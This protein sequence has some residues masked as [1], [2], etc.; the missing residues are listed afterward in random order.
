MAVAK[1]GRGT[2]FDELHNR[3]GAKMFRV[4]HRITRNRQDAE[5]AVQDCF[6]NAFIHLKSFDGRSRF[7]TWLTRIATNAAL[8]KLRKKFLTAWNQKP[9]PFVWTKSADV[10]LEK[11][12][13]ALDTFEAIN[14]GNQPSDSEH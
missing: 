12:R 11:E 9:K 2:A 7:S 14:A 10:I 6:L 1:K 3:H 5:D 4:V 8:M 13:R